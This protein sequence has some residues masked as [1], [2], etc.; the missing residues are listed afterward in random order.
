MLLLGGN[1][2]KLT[3]D[4]FDHLNDD[5]KLVVIDGG[6]ALVVVVAAVKLIQL[7]VEVVEK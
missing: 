2:C 4:F 3:N 5:E 1:D 7:I 6:D